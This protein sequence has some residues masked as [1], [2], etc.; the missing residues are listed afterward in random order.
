MDAGVYA[1]RQALSMRRRPLF[2]RCGANVR[3]HRHVGQA[4]APAADPETKGK[5]AARSTELLDMYQS[6]VTSSTASTR[7]ATSGV[8]RRL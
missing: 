8:L 4:T 3:G 1:Q 6:F 2:A 5:T 7:M